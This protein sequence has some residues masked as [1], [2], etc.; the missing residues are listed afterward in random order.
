VGMRAKRDVW[1]AEVGLLRPHGGRPGYDGGPERRRCR[2]KSR[3]RPMP[4]RSETATA[5]REGFAVGMRAKRGV[6]RAEVGL[7]RP[8]GGRPRN[9]GCTADRQEDTD[10]DYVGPVPRLPQ[11]SARLRGGWWAVKDYSAR[12]AS[13]CGDRRRTAPSGRSPRSSSPSRTRFRRTT[14][15]PRAPIICLTWCLRPSAMTM[16]R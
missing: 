1:R 15:P 2:L 11:P 6:W 9:D 16:L 8:H 4:G 7:L 13:S 12:R 3:A 10:S 14:L 5:F